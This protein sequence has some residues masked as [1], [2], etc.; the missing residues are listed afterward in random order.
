MCHHDWPCKDELLDF[1]Y[2]NWNRFFLKKVPS[3]VIIVTVKMAQTEQQLQLAL[4]F[5]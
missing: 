3:F 2:T 5:G 4:L 1:V